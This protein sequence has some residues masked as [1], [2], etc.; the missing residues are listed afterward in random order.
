MLKKLERG[1]KQ[2]TQAKAKVFRKKP[3]LDPGLDGIGPLPDDPESL[4]HGP[5]SAGRSTGSAK[6]PP[7]D[8][9]SKAFAGELIG[10]PFEAVHMVQPAVPALADE[11]KVKLGAPLAEILNKYP[12]FASKMTR[13]EIVFGFYLFAAV[14]GRVKIYA[15]YRKGQVEIAR[16]KAELDASKATANKEDEAPEGN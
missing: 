16:L 12:I 11:E 6:T 4:M 8:P 5:A 9:V 14:A 2:M 7:A 13:S 3:D 15:D 10:L 1:L